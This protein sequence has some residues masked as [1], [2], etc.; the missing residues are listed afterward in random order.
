MELILADA[1][2]A[3]IRRIWDDIDIDIGDMND[4]EIKIPYASWD[5][6]ITHGKRIYIPGTEFGGLVEDVRSSTATDMIYACGYTWRGY[7]DHKIIEPPSGQDYKTVSGELN[8][9]IRQLVDG[10]FNGLIVG[11]EDQTSVTTTYQ[12]DRYTTLEK[13]LEKML[14]RVGY[15]LQIRYLQTDLSGYVVVSAVPIENYGDSV[16]IS[17]DARLDF[18]SRDYRMGINHLICLG[19]GELKDRVVVHLYADA[20]GNISQTQTFTGKDE[21][22]ATYENTTAEQE[23]LITGGTDRLQE[24]ANYKEFVAEMA[25]DGDDIDLDVG[26]TITG[27]DY[28]TGI[29]VTKPIINKVVTITNGFPAVQYKVEG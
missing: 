2:G 8:A 26:D 21:I 1:N 16:E 11:T 3:E 19:I 28:I 24:L 14:K 7:L 17:Q 29:V 9:I 4:F 22:T 10:E 13:G 27:R 25:N 18:T 12:F 6:L 20:D 23:D 15:K 5:G